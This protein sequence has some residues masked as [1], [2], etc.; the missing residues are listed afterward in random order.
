MSKDP[1]SEAVGP[2]L[3]RLVEEK[4]KN[5]AIKLGLPK[6]ELQGHAWNDDG[7][8]LQLSNRNNYQAE[9]TLNYLRKRPVD[10]SVSEA[11]DQIRGLSA[12]QIEAMELDRSI[13]RS[14]T[15]EQLLQGHNWNNEY[16]VKAT[17][18]YLRIRP[19]DVCASQ[20]MDQIRGLNQHQ[21]K[22]MELNRNIG[23]GLTKEQLLQG[24]DW[25]NEH[26]AEATLNYLRKCPVDVSLSQAMDNIRG[27]ESGKIKSMIK[28]YNRG[29]NELKLT[30]EQ[31]YIRR[32]DQVMFDRIKKGETYEAVC[33]EAYKEVEKRKR[34]TIGAASGAFQLMMEGLGGV[35]QEVKKLEGRSLE[36]LGQPIAQYL[37]SRDC[38][39]MAQAAKAIFEKSRSNATKNRD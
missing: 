17:L 8:D 20:A 4:Y 31:V 28:A 38:Q 37:T 21:I 33:K 29:I 11:M 22:A 9:A 12:Y 24:H 30:N 6:S 26:Q 3:R 23:R 16:V 34:C 1:Y 13:G 10:V 2:S 39:N 35:G 18:H 25:N 19:V 32:F 27:F 14:L 36:D 7:P 15:R 5:E